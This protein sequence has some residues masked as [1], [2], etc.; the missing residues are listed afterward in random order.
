MGAYWTSEYWT[1][2]IEE[3]L[4]KPPTKPIEM[5]NAELAFNYI[6]ECREND[7]QRELLEA[8]RMK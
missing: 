2:L 4:N 5:Q 1:K 8:K 6:M 3:R 7:R